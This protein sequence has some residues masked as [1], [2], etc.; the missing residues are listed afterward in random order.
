MERDNVIYLPPPEHP[1]PEQR[2]HWHEQAAY[3]SEVQESSQR[4]VEYAGR[5]REEYLRLLGM[6]AVEKGIQ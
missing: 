1:T 2:A 4:Q 3:W 5:Q 6:L